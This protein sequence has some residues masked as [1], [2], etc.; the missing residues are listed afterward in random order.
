VITPR[1]SIGQRSETVRRANLAAIATQLHLDGPLSRSELVARTGLTRSAIRGLIGE[2][3]AAGLVN[4]ERSDSLGAP[5]RPSPIVTPNGM[6]AVA[7]GLEISVDSLAAGL[8]GFAGEVHAAVRVER[9]RGH[10]AA[11]EIVA[12]LVEVATPLLRRAEAG[13]LMGVGVAVVGIVRRPDGLVRLAP[14][15]GWRDVPLGEM[16]AQALGI[17]VPIF[18][19]NDADLGVLAEHRRGTARGIEDAFYLAGEVGVGGGALV[20]G[21]PMHGAEGYAGEIGHLP[22]NPEGLDCACGSR[23]CW[24][25][26]VGEHA[27][28]AAAGRPRDGGPEEVGRLLDAAAAGDPVALAAFQRALAVRE[29]DPGSPE[30]IALARYAVGKALRALGRSEEAVPL[31]EEAVAP[32]ELDR[33]ALKEQLADAEQRKVSEMIGAELGYRYVGS[34]LIAAEPGE[35]PGYDFM[36]YVPTTWPGARLPHVWLDDG[37]ALHDRIGD[38]YTLLRLGG[39]PEAKTLAAAFAAYGAPFRELA[40]ADA[41]PRDVYG[42]DLLLLRPDLHVVW[43]GNRLPDDPAGL[44]AIATGH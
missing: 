3:V 15:L 44:A 42:C 34:P 31:V 28:L 39:A 25:T 32:E 19:A 38:G 30:P 13:T 23:G 24:E 35:G 37:T 20:D 21:R 8:I 4:E 43:R 36:S 18:V 29:E 14:N 40:I 41:R 10:L 22:V 17:E 5:G 27:L 16:L 11:T 9:P 33:G 12:D 2:F 1:D 6:S 26:E 7:L